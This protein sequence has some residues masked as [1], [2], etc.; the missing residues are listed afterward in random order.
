MTS[1]NTTDP[2]EEYCISIAFENGM[3]RE[4]RFKNF[5][6][7]KH[8]IDQLAAA[9]G[10]SM[11]VKL[12]NQH[13]PENGFECIS[14]KTV[15]GLSARATKATATEQ[16]AVVMAKQVG[17]ALAAK[18]IVPAEQEEFNPEPPPAA[19]TTAAQKAAG[20]R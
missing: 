14:M 15:I 12:G 5:A 7:Y 6:E 3:A 4:L 9:Y 1:E 8:T 19:G 20:K 17:E 16:E 18:K 13:E 11:T 10:R 2:I